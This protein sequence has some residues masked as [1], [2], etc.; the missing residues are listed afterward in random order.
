MEDPIEPKP[1]GE[2]APAPVQL[3]PTQD[4][5]CKKMDAFFAPYNFAVK[6]S[7]MFR[8]ALFASQKSLRSS[9]QDWIAQASHSL[10]EILYPFYS[11]ELNLPMDTELQKY[12]S[13][14]AI[15]DSS[16]RRKALWRQLNGVSHHGA[17]K[18]NGVD[19]SI[20]TEDDFE[21]MISEFEIVMAEALIRQTDLH[22][23][24][25]DIIKTGP[26]KS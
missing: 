13:V 11:P 20:F 19:F 23:T 17:V 10:R 9:N 22:G 6:P 3:S 16:P 26:P 8:G 14:H 15:D 4:E 18:R 7:S 24:I 12:G 2:S 25:E 21:G 1:V 5:L